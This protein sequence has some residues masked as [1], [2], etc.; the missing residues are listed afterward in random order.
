MKTLI[1]EDQYN[2][3]HVKVLT[4]ED[5]DNLNEL[6]GRRL[7]DVTDK[8]TYVKIKVDNEEDFKAVEEIMR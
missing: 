2:R 3:T 5:V 1:L 7:L 4:A 6:L 8:E